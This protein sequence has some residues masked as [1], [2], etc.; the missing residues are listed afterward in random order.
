MKKG[1]TAMLTAIIICV[2]IYELFKRLCEHN[3]NIREMN[4]KKEKEK[5]DKNNE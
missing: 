2:T 4:I 3:E 5:E 1:K